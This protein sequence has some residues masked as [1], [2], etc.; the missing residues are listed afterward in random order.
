MDKST[1]SVEM[2]P[3]YG[4]TTQTA[5]TFLQLFKDWIIEAIT[6]HRQELQAIIKTHKTLVISDVGCWDGS[7]FFDSLREI[8]LKL[9]EL[10][11]GDFK[12]KIIYSDLTPYPQGFLNELLKKPELLGNN[13][14][15]SYYKHS[16]YEPLPYLSNITLCTLGTHWLSKAPSVNEPVTT[17]FPVCFKDRGQEKME[18]LAQEDLQDFFKAR[19]QDTSAFIGLVNLIK[20]RTIEGSFSF[21]AQS[22]MRFMDEIF[23]GKL[24]KKGMIS[25]FYRF[26]DEF[27][28]EA[29]AFGYQIDRTQN[30]IFHCDYVKLYQ[31]GQITRAQ[32]IE[33]EVKMAQAW[34][35]GSIAHLLEANQVDTFYLELKKCFEKSPETCGSD[36]HLQFLI[37]TPQRSN[38]I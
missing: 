18:K 22:A 34:S 12:I 9:R 5:K 28:S 37:L 32:L 7:H 25:L 33:A 20:M 14:E 24:K 31:Q 15:T 23:Y 30:F 13:V 1:N 3:E 21:T 26:P 19:Q 35:Q 4:N 6:T 8:I 16:F 36:Y 2:S 29:K 17:L 38:S 27:I 10:F 11:G